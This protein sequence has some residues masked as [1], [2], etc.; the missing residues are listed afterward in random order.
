MEGRRRLDFRTLRY[1][2]D[3][4]ALIP[5]LQLVQDRDGYISRERMLEI[6]RDTGIPLSEIYGVA[7]FF[8]QFRLAPAG[9]HVIRVCHGTACHVAG[10]K[11]ITRSLED[12]LKVATGET[13]ADRLFTLEIVSC[14]GCC[15]LAPVL[16]IDK[17]THGKL[18]P[19]DLGRILRRY[20]EA[21]RREMAT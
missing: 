1:A 4:G 13:S 6:H 2:D 5:A 17:A 15:C 12:R 7:T 9:K 21:A 8:A 11:I 3:D 16:M 20:R 19:A 14:L 18:R 10:A